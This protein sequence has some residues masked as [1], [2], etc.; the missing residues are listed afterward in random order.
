MGHIWLHKSMRLLYYDL[1][2]VIMIMCGRPRYMSTNWWLW[3]KCLSLEQKCILRFLICQTRYTMGTSKHNL[4]VVCS[5]AGNRANVCTLACW[6]CQNQCSNGD[7][8]TFGMYTHLCNIRM[9]LWPSLY[10]EMK[11]ICTKMCALVCACF[12]MIKDE[13][14]CLVHEDT[15]LLLAKIYI[16]ASMFVCR[17]VCLSVCLSVC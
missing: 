1:P 9:Y 16:L 11:Y 7:D 12:Y 3:K 4:I 6:N 15:S 8:I 14:V 5:R 10:R 13:F 2:V 17:F